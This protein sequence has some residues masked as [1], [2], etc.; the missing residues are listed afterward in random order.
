[1]E[2]NE[3]LQ[4][5]NIVKNEK[6]ICDYNF[7]YT[8]IRTLWIIAGTVKETAMGHTVQKIKYNKNAHKNFY[9]DYIHF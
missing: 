9:V 8:N 4:S 1:M 3:I 5:T 2:P 7:R 6:K